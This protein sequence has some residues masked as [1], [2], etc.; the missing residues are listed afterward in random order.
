MKYNKYTK[1]VKIEPS[2]TITQLAEVTH[3]TVEEW[4]IFLESLINDELKE[5]KGADNEA[6]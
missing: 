3:S 6:N 2:D 5:W 4:I 1:K